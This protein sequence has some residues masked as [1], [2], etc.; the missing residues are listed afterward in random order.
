[1]QRVTITIETTSR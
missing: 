1:M